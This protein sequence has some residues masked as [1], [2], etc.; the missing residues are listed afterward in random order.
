MTGLKCGSYIHK[1]VRNI[2]SRFIRISHEIIPSSRPRLRVCL[3]PSFFVVGQAWGCTLSQPSKVR[4]MKREGRLDGSAAGAT[5]PGRDGG[6]RGGIT[7]DAGYLRAKP[8]GGAPPRH[9]VNRIEEGE[10]GRGFSLNP[11][12]ENLRRFL[13]LIECPRN[14]RKK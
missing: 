8:A 5:T 13:Q 9:L 4:H 12:E 10:V 1:N 11:S 3:R 7:R 14:Y 6:A 2:H